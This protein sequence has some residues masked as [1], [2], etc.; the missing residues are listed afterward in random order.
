MGRIIEF[1]GPQGAGKTT[2]AEVMVDYLNDSNINIIN[3][4]KRR[5]LAFKK[6]LLVEDERWIPGKYSTMHKLIKKIVISSPK[7]VVD[8]IIKSNFFSAKFIYRETLLDEFI[9]EN[10]DIYK[11]SIDKINRVSKEDKG[12]ILLSALETKFS[13]YQNAIKN[14]DNETLVFCEG[15]LHII[16]KSIYSNIQRKNLPADY[17]NDLKELVTT[18]SSIIDS[19]IFIN[20]DPKTCFE[21]QKN[22]GRLA[23]EKTLSKQDI[24]K[25]LEKIQKNSLLVHETLKEKGVNSFEIKNNRSFKESEEKIKEIS[26][27]I[28]PFLK[29]N[30]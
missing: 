24:L 8:K 16:L 30:N 6:W 5:D 13:E 21:R 22:R 18:M 29:S 2:L 11:T 1:Y 19:A 12:E 25:D 10:A 27:E 20:T 14:F 17:R 26:D 4:N 9:I 23:G 28:I 3:Y 15:G 7:I